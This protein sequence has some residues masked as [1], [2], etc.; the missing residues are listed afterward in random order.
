MGS[1]I[2]H[3]PIVCNFVIEGRLAHSNS[4]NVRSVHRSNVYG[5]FDS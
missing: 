1:E 5:L 4:F 3:L 2:V